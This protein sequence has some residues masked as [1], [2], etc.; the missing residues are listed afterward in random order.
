MAKSTLIEW[1]TGNGWLVFAGG[2]QDN[3]EIRAQALSRADADGAVACISFAPDGGDALLDDLEDLGA[4]SGYII[5]LQ[6]EDDASVITQLKNASVVV[7]EVD[8]SLNVL[9]NAFNEATI[10]GLREAYE[11]GAII[12][13]EG[14]AMNLFGKWVVNDDGDVL[15]GLNWVKNIFLEPNATSADESRAVQDILTAHPEAI[16]IEIGELSALALGAGGLIEVWGERQ[17]TISL[18]KQY[19]TPST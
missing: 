14:L 19:Q 17:V 18:G 9:Y 3:G 5:D 10:G 8:D 6:Y 12:L 15:D 16:A 4:P 11:N 13:L 2:S 1:I 7:I